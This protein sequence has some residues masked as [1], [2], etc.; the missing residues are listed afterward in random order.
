MTVNSTNWNSILI[1]IL[2][3]CLASC[4]DGNQAAGPVGSSPIATGSGTFTGVPARMPEVTAFKGIRYAAAPEGALRW[5]PP[6]PAPRAEGMVAADTYG[7]SCPQDGAGAQSEDCLFLNVYAPSAA[8]RGSNLPVLVFVHGGAFLSGN[9]SIYDATSMVAENNIIVVTLNYRLGAL[10]LLV[11]PGL[12]ATEAS[13]FENVGDGGNYGFI[14][15][16][17]ALQ[18][19]RDNIA[20]FG[21]APD[22]VTM[23]GESAGGQS[24]F[25]HL[26]SPL[27]AQGLFHGII[28]QS[29]G[30][31]YNNLPSKTAVQEKFAEAFAADIGCA[32]TDGDCFR[33]KPVAD[34]LVSQN[35]VFGRYNLSPVH[36][37]KALPLSFKAAF[38]SGQ[39]IKVPVMNGTTAHEGRFFLPNQ[40]PRPS[41]EDAVAAGGPA[42][43]TLTHANAFCGSAE[44]PATCTYPSLLN[45][46]LGAGLAGTRFGVVVPTINTP[47]FGQTLADLY[48]METFLNPYRGNAPN[49]D[50]A[51]ARVF[52][53]MVMACNA[54]AANRVLAATGIPVFAYEF[55]DP[56]A[57]SRSSPVQAPNNLFGYPSGAEHTSELQ[58]LYDSGKGFTPEQA[59]LARIMRGYWA[60][61]ARA[62]DPGN[63]KLPAFKRFPAVQRLVPSGPEPTNT[64]DEDHHCTSF[65]Q[66]ILTG[67]QPSKG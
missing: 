5:K 51:L 54:L 47:A 21:G 35:R 59:E 12:L 24:A 36:G 16:Q 29:S 4:G 67:A 19:L 13:H 52:T 25:F 56:N 48:P 53:D 40:L 11:E 49:A 31:T 10:G 50:M 7:A 32:A 65:W 63:E 2:A 33:K 30:S 34:I 15:Q 62:L 6:Q 41:L 43:F 61:F 64:F 27:T 8:K 39:I 44:A 57:P 26:A 28:S 9:G 38:Q 42:N 22:K 37:T 1:G 46:Y 18:W 3:M 45:R 55:D 66:P 17:F 23:T 60:N 58:Y 20:A 14:D